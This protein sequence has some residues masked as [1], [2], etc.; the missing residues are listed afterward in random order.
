M[1]TKDA[2][3]ITVVTGDGLSIVLGIG[4]CSS[5]LVFK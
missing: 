5:G 1:S 3:F 4:K 2:R